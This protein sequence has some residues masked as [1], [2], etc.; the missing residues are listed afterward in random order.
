ERFDGDALDL[1]ADRVALELDRAESLDDLLVTN[2]P[3][4][5]GPEREPD[6]PRDVAH[7]SFDPRFAAGYSYTNRNGPGNSHERPSRSR[8]RQFSQ[9]W[10]SR[11]S[12]YRTSMPVASSIGTSDR[13]S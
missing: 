6:L 13:F 8:S 4:D 2:R 7:R 12:T 10:P 9:L 11:A 3:A 5:V 1:D